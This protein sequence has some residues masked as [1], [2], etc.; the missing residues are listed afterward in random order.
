MKFCT[1]FC[2]LLLLADTLL[3]CG[4]AP[5]T[6][7]RFN[8]KP[9]SPRSVKVGKDPVHILA[10][11]GKACCEVVIPPKS[12]AAV[13]FA[14]A[15]L[16][17]YLGKITNSQIPA[18]PAPTGK[19]TAFILGEP[20]AKLLGFDLKSIDR[21]GYIIKSRGKNI[22]IAGTDNPRANPAKRADAFERGTLYG[23]YEF[24][25]RFGGVRFYFPGEM[26][27]VVPLK[28]DWSIGTIDLID[29]PDSQQRTTYC[30][31][32]K[33]L[34]N[35][36]LNIHEGM[37]EAEIRRLSALRIRES[38]L[39]IPKCHGLAALNLVKRY[40]K[41]KPEFFALRPD[42]TRHD[43]SRVIRRDDRHGQLCFSNNELREVVFQDAK[44]FLS[45]KPAAAIGK[46][47]WNRNFQSMP[48]INIMPN[49]ALFQCSCSSCKK[50]YDS[51]DP[52]A[53]SDHIWKFKT[54]IARKLQQKK[55]PGFVTM[56][57]YGSYK[58]IPT[59]EI[60]D[61]VIVMLALTGPWKEKNPVQQQDIDLL[62]AW[63]KKLNAKTHLWTY[64]TKI[65]NEIPDVPSF[66]PRATGSFFKKVAPYTFGA[67]LE[68]ET[69]FWI[70]NSM[71]YYIFGKV[72][73]DNNTDVDALIKEHC[74]LMYGPA[75]AEMEQ[76]YDAIEN[77]WLKDIMTNI[78]DTP[79][80]PKVVKPSQFDI[81]EKIYG[82][83]E[84]KR[85]NALLDKAEK[86]TLQTPMANKRVKFMRKELWGPVLNG[87]K[88][89]HKQ[90]KDKAL[91]TIYAD[92]ADSPIVID[93]KLSEKAWQ[94]ADTVWM[95]PRRG[96]TAEVHTRV[97]ML[98]DEKYFYI[99]IESDEPH[100]DKM[101]CA[102]RKF[103]EL[104][105]WQ[106]NLVELFFA[107]SPT[108]KTIYQIMLTSRGDVFDSRNIPGLM[109]KK[110]NSR[111]QY[112][113][114]VIPGRMWIA[115][116]KIPRSSMPDIKGNNF[117]VNFTRGRVLNMPG[118]VKVPY[119]TWSPFP[120]NQRAE[121]CGTAIIG[122]KPA[123]GSIVKNGDFTAGIT[124]KRFA[125]S[126]YTTRVIHLDRTV[127]RTCGQSVRLEPVKGSNLLRQIMAKNTFKP[128]T[129]YRLSYFVKLE[130][131]NGKGDKAGSGF[132]AMIRFG[133]SGKSWF[134]PTRSAFRGTMSWR[135]LEYEFTTPADP[136]SRNNPYLE[137]RISLHATGKAWVDHVEI[138]EI[139][140]K[141]K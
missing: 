66:T 106:D 91:W 126:W 129:R 69:D 46:K 99:G 59:M 42:G 88:R 127:Y 74:R 73:W 133:G 48:F 65:G 103:D 122:T 93:G 27:T 139:P 77:H 54:W 120:R 35:G 81:W 137:F 95:I 61:N 11:K 68:S 19:R 34:G 70:F 51:K 119:Y 71:N 102:P 90:N 138:V 105:M 131:V 55:I 40:A 32:L 109:E 136:G 97:K 128:N 28:K 37:T 75:A 121:N 8:P 62:K 110:W 23:V 39:F 72:L 112:K 16:Q 111:L 118:A 45:G 101:L 100:T 30:V 76:F 125:G 26:G 57:A 140:Q 44:A 116:V 12:C 85:I 13:K 5:K 43:G 17:T 115:E 84:I 56:M 53:A 7:S 89:F 86:L 98:C 78:R 6:T 47:Y 96:D 3:L 141:R 67:F 18:V 63:N 24:L 80:G 124:G 10:Q 29:R 92:K 52:L 9:V 108:S 36:K 49:D 79:V 134:Y 22:I 123:S 15:E 25:E 58:P 41:S 64:T 135:R 14:A 38:T 31:G 130:N 33:S 87:M 132:S 107:A 82:P 4:A 117:V 104:N 21:D 114:G 2:L 60:P 113:P 20:G 1:R 50:V 83:T 94:K